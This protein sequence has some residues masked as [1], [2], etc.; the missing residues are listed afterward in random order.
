MDEKTILRGSDCSSSRGGLVLGSF[1]TSQG[2]RDGG[3]GLSGFPP[4][5]GNA[6]NARC[7]CPHTHCLTPPHPPELNNEDAYALSPTH[8]I[9]V[10]G[11]P[12]EGSGFLRKDLS[13]RCRV[14][15]LG[16]RGGGPVG[17]MRPE[18]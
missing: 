11:H 6:P 14:G 12:E 3:R 5:K 8:K 1:Y 2:S 7:L 4:I 9:W 15:K 18:E 13:E 17:K 16:I 10:P